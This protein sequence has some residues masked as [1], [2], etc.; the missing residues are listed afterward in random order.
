LNKRNV[1]T[2]ENLELI[3]TVASTG[4]MS[5]AA[6]ALHLVPSAMSYR[7]RQMEDALDVLLF[8]RSSRKATLTAAGKELLASGNRMLLELDALASRV[9]RV[10][11]GWEPSF[12]IA[13][14]S[15]IASE[16]V[17]ELCQQFLATEA[18][19]QIRLM[20]E[21]LSGT[22]EALV[23]GRADLAL[24]GVSDSW[25][26][27]DITFKPLGEVRFIF[28]VAPHHPLA[29]AREP[30][31]DEL[32]GRHLAIAVADSA[33]RGPGMTIGLLPGQSVLTVPDMP[34]KLAAQLRGIGCGFLPE[35]L[36]A[37]YLS[38]GRLV[39]K[40]TER[41][42]R[43]SR[44]NY[45]WRSTGLGGLALKWWLEALSK[46]RTRQALLSSKPGV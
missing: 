20:S 45:A 30:L 27:A 9:K 10:A 5:A 41:P 18:P 33:N 4:S 12:T 7:V 42:A 43:L 8:D 3:A 46:P 37:P 14:D 36:A 38:A 1:L 21:T 44:L 15:L 35:C 11:T 40:Q 39:S 28:A 29:K 17:F 31:K 34:A 26:S 13:I 25:A 6:R 23:S 22:Y 19:T 2:P 16:A 24:G 32:I